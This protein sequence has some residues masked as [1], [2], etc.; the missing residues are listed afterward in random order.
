MFKHTISIT[1]CLEVA[2]VTLF[3]YYQAKKKARSR[4][5]TRKKNLKG[6]IELFVGDLWLMFLNFETTRCQFHKK[7]CAWRKIIRQILLLISWLFKQKLTLP[8]YQQYLNLFVI[9]K[10]RKIV[11]LSPKSLFWTSKQPFAKYFFLRL[12]KGSDYWLLKCDR[13][14]SA[15]FPDTAAMTSSTYSFQNKG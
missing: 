13:R 15:S 5:N 10:R 2:V 14:R 7:P 3:L 4:Q 9:K 11:D 12:K 6:F 8:L 1:C